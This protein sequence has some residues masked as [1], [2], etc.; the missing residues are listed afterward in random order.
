[1]TDV[2]APTPVGF[3]FPGPDHRGMFFG[4]RAPQALIL[5][6]S[7]LTAVAAM[8]LVPSALGLAMGLLCFLVGAG[9]AFVR[10][11]GQQ[12]DQ[13]APVVA[14]WVVR[15][16]RSWVSPVPLWGDTD[17]GA[18]VRSAPPPT[19]RGVAFLSVRRATGESVG[20]VKDAASGT[21]CA[22]L[23]CRGTSFA[24]LDGLEQ[25]RLTALWGQAIAG[26]AQEGSPVARV[27]WVERTIP[28]EGDALAAWLDAEAVLGPGDPAFDSYS[29]LIASAGPASQRHE[30]YVV[31]AIDAS[32]ARKAIRQAGGGDAGATEVVLRELD[33][34]A[35]RL[36]Q[37]DVEVSGR[38][39]A[40]AL[41]GAVRVAF[42]PASVHS[43]ATRKR[44]DPSSGGG[45]SGRN[46][47]PMATDTAWSH[48]R[49]DSGWHATFH[50]AEW[51]RQRVSA[52]FL[53]PLILRP[54]SQHSLAV[55]MEPVPPSRAARA[56]E[57]AH[58]SHVADEEL[59]ARA[60]YLETARRR[61]Q[62][63]E[64][65][66]REGELARGHAEV[67]FAGYVTVTA[68]TEDD[69]EFAAGEIEQLGFDARV[70]LRRLYGRQ[71]EAFTYTLP[72]A[73]G[74]GRLAGRGR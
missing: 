27:A 63:E 39:D 46:A 14:K 5:A 6:A 70:E 24:L 42:D 3:T 47:W 64:L 11:G 25:E 52:S 19:L 29:E 67:R 66:R 21:W 38:L 71:D 74:L 30:A 68:R 2:P 1:V 40:R 50:V 8:V 73:R 31:V 43:V 72:L 58:A 53:H 15:R 36:R 17:D 16:D 61:R 9:A 45:V 23:A 28:E 35:D 41:A 49:T 59:R 55:V 22:A 54:R 4:L 10:V 37:A 12:V 33:H 62:H 48:Y 57:S 65:L 69:L 18:G 56:V 44:V 60:G 13:W 7:V 34:L 26:F 51:P 32:R 20:V